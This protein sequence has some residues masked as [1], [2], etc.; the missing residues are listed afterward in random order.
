MNFSM[1]Y[2]W[3]HAQ[4]SGGAPMVRGSRVTLATIHERVLAGEPIEAV[5]KDMELNEL[6]TKKAYAEWI[7]TK[8]A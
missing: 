2:I 4:I 5:C 3:Q 1:S 6:H 7:K 8:N